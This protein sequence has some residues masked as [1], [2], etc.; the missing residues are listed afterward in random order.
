MRDAL[1]SVAAPPLS[2]EPAD[3]GLAPVTNGGND[4][5]ADDRAYAAHIRE[6]FEAYVATRR[7]CG[8]TVATLTLDKFQAR[9][10]TNRQQLVA[11]YGC[12]SARF[13][14]YV[15]DGKAAVKATPLR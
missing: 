12:R 6:V 13:S 15:K 10:E 14:V 3:D 7:R 4:D 2:E 11:K 9:L 1:T 8:E 5:P